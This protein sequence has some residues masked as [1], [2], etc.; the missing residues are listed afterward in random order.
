M[1][2]IRV[3]LHAHQRQVVSEA[4]RF[5]V[6]MCVAPPTS[7]SHRSQQGADAVPSTHGDADQT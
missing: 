5:N 6:L 3:R 1:A 4:R 7:P 2:T